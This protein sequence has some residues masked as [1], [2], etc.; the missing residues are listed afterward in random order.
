MSLGSLWVCLPTW[1]QQGV[2]EASGDVGLDHVEEGEG[3]AGSA[4]VAGGVGH[5]GRVMGGGCLQLQGKQGRWHLRESL[6][7][8]AGDGGLNHVGE[9]EGLGGTAALAGGL[10]HLGGGQ[11]FSDCLTIQ[12]PEAKENPC[13][14]PRH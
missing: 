1:G 14:R 10:E 6:G 2:E 11:V 9:G 5:L 13:I 3:L 8:A 12:A 7:D 4:V